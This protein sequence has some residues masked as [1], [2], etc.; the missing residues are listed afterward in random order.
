MATRKSNKPMAQVLL[1]LLAF[2]IHIQT[3]GST[4][5]NS[6][7]LANLKHSSITVNK[8]SSEIDFSV[9]RRELRS[10]G[11]GGGG[12]GGGGGSSGGRGGGSVSRGGG[13]NV[14]TGT[15]G[16]S[17]GDCLKQYGL[18]NSL[19]FIGLLGYLVGMC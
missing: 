9:W 10:G 8:A 17:S 12:R 18:F 15:S 2:H 11:G 13:S 4:T 6:A 14:G 19:L 16:K 5:E 1:L 3:V 7:S